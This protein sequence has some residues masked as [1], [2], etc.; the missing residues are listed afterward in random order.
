MFL[1]NPDVPDFPSNFGGILVRSFSIYRRAFINYLILAIITYLPFL[2]IVQISRF[3]ILDIIEFFHGH[4]LDIL[5]FLTLPTFFVDKRVLP[6]GTIQLFFQRFFASAVVLSI[7]QFSTL[8]ISMTFFAQISLGAI[9]IGL[10]PYIFLLFSG[11]FLIMENSQKLFSIK[12]NLLNSVKTVKT[13][14]FAIFWNYL[15]I[16]I[17]MF[18]PLFFFSLWYFGSH[19]DIR[20]LRDAINNSTGS[21]AM[22][23]QRFLDV[24]QGISQEPGFLWSRIGI[25]VL[26]RPL[27]SIFLAIL[28]LSI[29]QRISPSSV[30][31]YIGLSEE[32]EESTDTKND[33]KDEDP[34]NQQQEE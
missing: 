12:N 1:S 10:I 26:F 4:F 18:L 34:Y 23:G 24:L 8:I 19:P 3:D 22:L 28:F 25:H 14:F 5:V 32:T 20:S 15:N 13:Q 11:Y 16:T 2:L 30:N 31:A 6:L 33:D 21:D 27:K 17:F 29:L 7:I 9:L